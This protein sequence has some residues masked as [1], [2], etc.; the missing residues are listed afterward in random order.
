M[1]GTERL[2]DFPPK[3]TPVPADIIYSGDSADAFNEVQITIEELISAY[4]GLLSIGELTTVADR[5]IY[6]TGA[7]TYAVTTLTAAARNILAQTSNANIMSTLGALPLAG[8]TML[9]ALILS[10]NSPSTALEAAS[11]GYVDT[12]ATGLEI[13]QSCR[14]ATTGALTATYSNGSSGVGATLTNSGAQAALSIDGVSLSVNDRVLV[15]NQGSTFQNGI[16]F[17][18]D[19]GSGSTNWVLTRALDYDTPAEIQPGT[20]VLIDA[21]TANAATGWIE[22]AT[23]TTIGTDPITFTQFGVPTSTLIRTVKFQSITATG[24]YTPSAG[25]I[26][27]IVQGQGSGGG[28]GGASSGGAGQGS[29]GGGGGGGGNVLKVYTAAQMGASA[30]VVI[31]AHGNGGAAGSNAGTAGADCTFTPAGGGAVLTA[32]GGAGGQPGSS[33]VN[34]NRASGGG[35]GIGSGGDFNIRGCPGGDGGCL[36]AGVM[37]WGGQGGGGQLAP[38]NTA[39]ISNAN[40]T[41]SAGQNYGAGGNGGVAITGNVAGGDGT[42]GIFN[43]IEFCNQ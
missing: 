31:G 22:T 41:G 2:L 4:P 32:G 5:M 16:Y 13:K 10:T 29:A 27:A 43:I 12:V 39:I 1:A 6:T 19:V 28:G 11:K 23:V 9:G 14:V 21:G 20:F 3:A 7:D 18:S 42:N 34:A 40:A 30:A 38:L 8:G 37:G 17:V 35:S 26:S 15:K 25:L 36:A 24:T 33:S